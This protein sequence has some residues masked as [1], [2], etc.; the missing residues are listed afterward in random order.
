MINTLSHFNKLQSFTKTD[1]SPYS[2]YPNIC[3]F[4]ALSI[5]VLHIRRY[6]SHIIFTKVTISN[7]SHKGKLS[8]LSF[9]AGYDMVKPAF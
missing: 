8:P 7:Q 9:P 3:S 2:I 4:V 5:Q 1:A 6:D